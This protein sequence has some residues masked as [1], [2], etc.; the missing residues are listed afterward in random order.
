MRNVVNLSIELSPKEVNN[1]L[2]DKWGIGVFRFAQVFAVSPIEMFMQRSSYPFTVREI[3]EIRRTLKKMR[4]TLFRGAR[5]I[6]EITEKLL[7]APGKEISDDE[8]AK[9]MRLGGYFKKYVHKHEI[10]TRYVEKI[11]LQGKRGVQIN[12]KSIIAIGWGNLVSQGK[13]R[14]SYNR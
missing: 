6:R 11:C 10:L 13:R 14:I 1:R 12:R 5:H 8:L 3:K 4:D 9:E 2:I 7:E